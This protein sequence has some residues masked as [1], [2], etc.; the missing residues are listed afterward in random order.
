VLGRRQA[1]IKLV[2]PHDSTNW[3]DFG[4]MDQYVTLA[5]WVLHY[6]FTPTGDPWLASRDWISHVTQTG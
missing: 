2:I 3:N 6:E 5:R 1:G 4:G